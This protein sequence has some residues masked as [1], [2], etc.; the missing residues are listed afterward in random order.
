MNNLP[1]PKLGDVSAVTITTTNLEKSL[2]FY[3]QLGFHELFRSDFPFPL[4]KISD[5]AIQIMLRQDKNPYIALTYYVKNMDELI[6]GL[7]A[8]GLT[9]ATKPNPNDMVQRC[10]IKSPDGANISLV[11]FVDGFTQPTGATLLTMSPADY[12][13]PEKYPNQICGIFGEF[14]HPVADFD[15]SLSFWQKLGFKLLTSHQ[16]PYKWG[17]LTDGLNII[18][19]HQTTDFSIPTITYF[20]S[21]SK[22]KIDK[23]KVAGL[24]SYI[25]KGLNNITFTS[26]EKQQINLFKLGM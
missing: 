13:K 4:I 2:A 8:D 7:E 14:A 19:L 23:I 24:T 1:T 26:P 25:E 9:I 5:G 11:T 20:A 12:S 3:Q 10:L 18:G 15:V 17:I 6:A 22:Q 16:M 21:D